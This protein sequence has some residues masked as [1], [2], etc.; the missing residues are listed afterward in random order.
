MVLNQYLLAL[1]LTIF[2]LL[3]IC[4]TASLI[5]LMVFENVSGSINTIPGKLILFFGFSYSLSLIAVYVV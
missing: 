3:L 1:S 5:T 2:L 4:E